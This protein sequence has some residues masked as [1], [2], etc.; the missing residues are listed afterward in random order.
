M[1]Q[2]MLQLHFISATPFISVLAVTPVLYK[3]LISIELNVTAA[4]IK[5]LRTLLGNLSYPINV[6]NGI[7]IT[8]LNIS[9]GKNTVI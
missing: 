9:T 7:V 4:T 5:Q 1:L 8:E 3:Y 2:V 6:T